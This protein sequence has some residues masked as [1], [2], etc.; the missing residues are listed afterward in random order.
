MILAL[1]AFVVGAGMGVSL[2]FDNDDGPHWKN[3]TE[4]MTTNLNET[5]NFTYDEEV[6]G[7]DFNSNE[8]LTELNVTVKPSY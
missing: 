4:E 7:V 2:S 6:D 5:D 3:V 1:V 8:T